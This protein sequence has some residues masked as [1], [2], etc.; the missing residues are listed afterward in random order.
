M[1][2]DLNPPLEKELKYLLTKKEYDALMRACRQDILKS[3][4]QTN[5]YF[6]N[7]SLQLRKKRIGL[8]V[9]IENASK[10]TL[11][12]KEP[13][14]LRSTKLPKLKI[15]KEWESRLS[16]ATAKSLVKGKTS[17]AS[18]NSKPI[19]VLKN[20]FSKEQLKKVSPLGSVK[21]SRTFVMADHKT[22]LE[23]D[24][25]KMFKKKFYELEVETHQP[26]IADAVVRSLL[27]KH[28]ISYRPITK[29]KL[30]RFLDLW[31]KQRDR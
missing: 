27:K 7:Q 2:T 14:K 31:K 16:L 8:R 29:S 12:V 10:C 6:D 5:F 11:T 22:L 24:K 26:V 20:H 9:R 15:R 25:Y 30:G 23:I 28:G 21:T 4:D 3:V 1:K 18:L 17:I 13:S 19:R